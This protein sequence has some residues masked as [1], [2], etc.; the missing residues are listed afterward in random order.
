MRRAKRAD[1][2]PR[3]ITYHVRFADDEYEQIKRKASLAQ[4]SI[5]DFIRRA[6]INKQV[7][8]DKPLPPVNREFYRELSA[9]GVNLNQLVRAMNT[10]NKA[11][12]LV[13]VNTDTIATM[14]NDMMRIIEQAQLNILGCDSDREDNQE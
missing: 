1:G 2:V 6:A 5:S 10:A 13:E 4:I 11:G 3:K 9:I 7:R 12:K 8:V 14:L